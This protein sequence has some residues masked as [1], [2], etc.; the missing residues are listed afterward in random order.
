MLTIS[1]CSEPVD[2]GNYW[3]QHKRSPRCHPLGATMADMAAFTLPSDFRMSTCICYLTFFNSI[4][5]LLCLSQIKNIT[6]LLFYSFFS[7][8]FF[9]CSN[10]I[11]SVQLVQQSAKFDSCLI[12]NDY[13]YRMRVVRSSFSF[14]HLWARVFIRFK[15]KKRENTGTLPFRCKSKFPNIF[16]PYSHFLRSRPQFYSTVKQDTR[17]GLAMVWCVSLYDRVASCHVSSVNQSITQ[18]SATWRRR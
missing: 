18:S 12:I 3:H 13:Y 17:F 6:L 8:T 4:D 2:E 16:N 11:S 5:I 14:I 10:V 9:I 15:K 1:P 7:E